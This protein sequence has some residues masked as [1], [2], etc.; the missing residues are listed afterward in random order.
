[1]ILI[2]VNIVVIVVVVVINIIGEKILFLTG[3]GELV[4]SLKLDV[5]E[6]VKNLIVIYCEI[7]IGLMLVVCVYIF[8]YVLLKE[9][10]FGFGLI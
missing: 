1:M 2:I 7:V 3:N 4:C 5:S 8:F 6:E 9:I 10:L